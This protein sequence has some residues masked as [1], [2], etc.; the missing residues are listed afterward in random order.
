MGVQEAGQGEVIEDTRLVPAADFF[1]GGGVL[2]QVQNGGDQGI[3][4]ADRDD[5]RGSG[6][7]DREVGLGGDGAWDGRVVPQGMGGYV[8]R[9]RGSR[10]AEDFFD[11]GGEGGDDGFAQAHGFEDDVRLSLPAGIEQHDLG[12][13]QVVQWIGTPAEKVDPLAAIEGLGLAF[14]GL[15]LFA[16]PDEDQ[17][18]LRECCQQPRADS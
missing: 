18:V 13:G 10:V 16:L 12:G 17:V 14:Q 1:G 9:S 11:A 4:G 15:A 7:V 5:L 6:L 2:D 8:R 3:W